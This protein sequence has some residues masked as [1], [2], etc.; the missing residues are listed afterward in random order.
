MFHRPLNRVQAIGVFVLGTWLGSCAPAKMLAPSQARG[1]NATISLPMREFR[2]VWVATVDNIDWPSE[3]GL[4][5]HVQ[6]AEAVAILHGAAEMGLNAIVLQVRPHCDALYASQL[7][8][9]SSYLSGVQGQAPDPYY[10]PLQFWISEAHLRGLE[11]HAWFNPFRADH[12]AN[13]SQLAANAIARQSPELA[14][15]LGDKGYRWL[16]PSRQE[17]QDHS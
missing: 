5:T 16:D 13:P 7:E 8:P 12:P 4:P 1:E 17:V 6:K 10:D 14:V 9:W 3:P 11:L 15:T 2:A